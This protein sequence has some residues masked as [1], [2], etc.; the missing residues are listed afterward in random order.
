MNAID[1]I[2]GAMTNT[3]QIT[4]KF[5]NLRSRSMVLVAGAAETDTADQIIRATTPSGITSLRLDMREL[6]VKRSYPLCLRCRYQ[7]RL[8]K[9]N[10]YTKFEGTGL[11]TSSRALLSKTPKTYHETPR[12]SK[13]LGL[14]RF[15][16]VYLA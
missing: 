6:C 4:A 11:L 1:T 3:R 13:L 9:Q 10:H 7:R 5:I 12:S 16:F 2:E 14:P 15:D 8:G